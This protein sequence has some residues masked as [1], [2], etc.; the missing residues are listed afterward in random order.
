VNT[1]AKRVGRWTGIDGLG[2]TALPVLAVWGTAD[3]VHPFG[4]TAAL[5][6]RVPQVELVALQGKGHAITF[7]ETETVLGHVLPFP[8]ESDADDA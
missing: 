8:R 3:T 7:G 5:E 6:R 4:F 2:R 1:V